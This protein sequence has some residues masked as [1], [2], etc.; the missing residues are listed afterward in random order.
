MCTF[1]FKTSWNELVWPGDL[2]TSTIWYCITIPSS[3]FRERAN[4]ETWLWY[5]RGEKRGW[6]GGGGGCGCI[7]HWS[8][9]VGCSHHRRCA[10]L[11]S[12]HLPAAQQRA[13]HNRCQH[14]SQFK[15]NLHQHWHCRFKAHI[16]LFCCFIFLTTLNSVCRISSLQH[17]NNQWTWSKVISSPF[18]RSLIVV[19]SHSL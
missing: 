1:L 3:Y 16:R 10:E 7:C 15:S 4:L 14:W 18:G 12:Q 17:L 2:Q 9:K 11:S 5:Y 13:L 8:Y 19:R 6:G